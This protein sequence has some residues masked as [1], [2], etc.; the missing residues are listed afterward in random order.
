VDAEFSIDRSA[1]ISIMNSGH[2]AFKF[3]KSPHFLVAAVSWL[4]VEHI[5]G[6]ATD[7]SDFSSGENHLF[8]RRGLKSALAL[9]NCPILLL[10]ASGVRLCN[11]LYNCR[12]QH[13]DIVVHSSRVSTSALE[14]D[15]IAR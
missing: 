14:R 12:V 7:L 13:G 10:V 5:R 8:S 4:I 11:A 6:V 1:L 9:Y 2:S 3:A 15:L